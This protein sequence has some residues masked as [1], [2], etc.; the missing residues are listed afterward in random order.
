MWGGI[1]PIMAPEDAIEAD[2]DAVCIGEGEL[3]F[4]QFFDRFR[5]GEDFTSTPNFWFKQGDEITRNRFLPLAT[6]DEMESFPFPRY[7]GEEWI[8]TAGQGWGPMDAHDYI[9]DTGLGYNAI[10]SIGCPLRCTYCGNTKFIAN[11]RN[12]RKIRHTSAEYIVNE[13]KAVRETFPHISCVSFHDDSFMAIPLKRLERFAELWHDEV[14][15]PFS[16]YG[17]IPNY[18]RQDKFEV[19]TWAGM[20][21]IR[22]GIQTGSER[23]MEFYKR[24]TPIKS[25]ENAARVNASFS[26]KYHIPPA[27]DIITDNPIETRED[28]IDTLELLYRLDRPWT[29]NLFSLKVIPNTELEAALAEHGASVA[30]ISSNYSVVTPNLANILIYLLATVRP[31]RWLFERLLRHVKGSGAEQKEYPRLAFAMRTAYAVRRVSYH[32]RA[33][34]YSVVSGPFGFWMGRSGVVCFWRRWLTPRYPKPEST[35]GTLKP[36]LVVE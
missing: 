3:A 9:R 19:L 31:P 35:R 12:Y 4:E 15:I 11:D 10:W 16:V 34:D 14:G 30:E 26:P 1:H 17:V 5:E 8:Y 25:I 20:N 21:R 7:G 18:V 22:M 29:L 32:I 23:T 6:A 13:I 24:P 2:V 36:E 27:Y 28:V 33:M